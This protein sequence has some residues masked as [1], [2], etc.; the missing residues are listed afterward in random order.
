MTQ[1]I[2]HVNGL[3]QLRADQKEFEELMKDQ[4]TAAHFFKGGFVWDLPNLQAGSGPAMTIVR[5]VV[6]D[7]RLSG[8]WT[9]QTGA[10]Y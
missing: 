5:N 1:R 9:A 10:G 2:E 7:W 8:V 6:N 3:P 4:G